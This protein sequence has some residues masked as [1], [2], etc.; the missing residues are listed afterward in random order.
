MHARRGPRASYRPAVEPLEARA[1]PAA[2][3]STAF[4]TKVFPDLLNRPVD[5][6]GLAYWSSLVDQGFL[7]SQ[8]AGRMEATQEYRAGV[9][10]KLFSAY[11][12]RP[13]EPAAVAAWTNNLAQ[14]ASSDQLKAA[15]LGSD[16]YFAQFGGGTNAGFLA[17]AYSDVFGR[18]IDPSGAQTFG[19]R[20]AQGASRAGVAA[21][22]LASREA[23]ARVVGGLFQRY[24]HRA[25]D[26]GGLTSLVNQLQTGAS[27]EQLT[28][29]VIGSD[30]YSGGP[31]NPI[32]P[33]SN[34][35]P[36]TAAEV[37]AILSKAAGASASTDAII[38]VVDRP[39]HVLGVRIESSVVT[40][41]TGNAP[42]LTFAVD[43]ALSLARTA[44]FF[45]NDQAPLT[46]RT[47]QFISQSTVTQREVESNPNVADLNSPFRGPG[48]VAPIGVGGHFP[49]KV[50]DTPPVDLFGIEHTNRDS[51]INP[52][53]DRIKGTTDDV[54]L[55]TLGHERFNIDRTFVPPG[56]EL[57]APESYGFVSGLY[58]AGQSRGVGTLPGGIPIYKSGELVGGIGVFFPGTTGFATEENSVLSA[59]FNPAR[60]D[61]SLEAEYMAFAAVGNALPSGRIDLA[62]ITLDLVGPGGLQGVQNLLAYARSLRPGN[63]LDGVNGPLFAGD[64]FHVPSDP[65]GTRDGTAAPEGWLVMPHDGAGITAA[66]VARIINQGI[67]EANKVRAQIRLPA[68][69]R[70][71]MVFAVSDLNGDVVGMYRMH[72][73]TIFSEDVAVAKSRNTA[74]YDDPAQLLAIDQIA[75]LP[76]GVAFTNRTF[77]FV[78]QPRYPEGFDGTP[79]APMSILNDG[80]SNPLT[81]LSTGPA[82][83][84]SA[85]QADYGYDAFNPD[86]NFHQPFSL[87][88]NGVVWFPGS[89][90]VYK[91]VGG[92]PVLAGGFGVSGDG[93]DQDD[94]VTAT[95]VNGLGA[96]ATLMADQFFVRDVRLPYFKFPR[97]PEM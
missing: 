59:T 85:F 34:D 36:L 49:P 42:G 39:G 3:S 57:T 64:S 13:A 91:L 21:I 82:K 35:P 86:T 65:N 50:P 11:L 4:V 19:Q 62:G 83:P 22:L 18:P 9:V 31:V 37:S 96:P 52:G 40:A 10:Q 87:N 14:G 58:P 24:L 79:P 46:S 92:T 6:L 90:V 56:Q 63:P 29:A 61:R 43:G 33:P 20:L 51:I 12:R 48:F 45:A 15:L 70:T 67:T 76:K 95:G 80:G 47:V 30:E 93:V 73:A 23:Q 89:S 72:D 27:T 25:A 66:D 8:V 69:V 41:Y 26:P 88:Q 97:N 94:V 28:A 78:A 44:A 71:K 16:E 38:V 32:G 1:Q 74:Y 75:G 17:V 54:D 55:R 68:G 84:A 53:L 60:P 81:G 7:R 2:L 5:S 77:R